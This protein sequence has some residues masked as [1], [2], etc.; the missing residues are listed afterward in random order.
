MPFCPSVISRN[1]RGALGNLLWEA[2]GWHPSIVNVFRERRLQASGLGFVRCALRKLPTPFQSWRSLSCSHFVD[3]SASECPREMRSWWP[4]WIFSVTVPRARPVERVRC[5]DCPLI[6]SLM[7]LG[8]G[9]VCPQGRQDSLALVSP[10]CSAGSLRGSRCTDRVGVPGLLLRLCIC[11]KDLLFPRAAVLPVLFN[12][13]LG[14]PCVVASL[15][16]P[17]WPRVVVPP[18]AAMPLQQLCA[19]RSP[20]AALNALGKRGCPIK[21]L[22]LKPF[23][24]RVYLS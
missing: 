6:W 5:A 12:S 15:H 8:P 21:F 17:P 20:H 18:T 24:K 4:P 9:L 3:A 2:H 1:G 14:C 16:L 13:A 11:F 19:H 23:F 22:L 10:C 7:L